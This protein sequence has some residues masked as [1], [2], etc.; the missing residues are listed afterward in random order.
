MLKSVSLSKETQAST[1][2]HF[3]ECYSQ[4]AGWIFPPIVEIERTGWP[5]IELV[6]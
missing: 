3:R 1:A 5:D 2:L 4:E 6:L